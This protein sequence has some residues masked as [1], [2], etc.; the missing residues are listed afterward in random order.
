MP[1]FM[2]II[3]SYLKRRPTHL[4]NEYLMQLIFKKKKVAWMI[5]DE[6]ELR[7]IGF[8]SDQSSEFHGDNAF[9][10]E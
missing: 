3:T 8:A 6:E 2:R 9:D 5:S 1:T 7:R 10:F 4:E